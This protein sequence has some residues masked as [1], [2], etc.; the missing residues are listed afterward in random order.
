[1]GGEGAM[2]TMINSLKT[3]NR[4]RKNHS[5]FNKDKSRSYSK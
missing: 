5:A 3:N 4:R 2:M 1:M